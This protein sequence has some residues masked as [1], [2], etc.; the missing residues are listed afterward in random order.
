MPRLEHWYY[1]NSFLGTLPPRYK[2]LSLVEVYQ[3]LDAC[4]RLYMG[5]YTE[6]AVKVTY[7]GDVKIRGHVGVT[8]G[9]PTSRVGK[10]VI[11]FIETP[12]GS[13]RQIEKW[14]EWGFSSRIVEYPIK[15]VE[16]FKIMSYV[17]ENMHVSFNYEIYEKLKSNLKA[18]GMIW[19][20]FP[21][22]PFQRLL[23]D[24]VG[25]ERTI[26]LLF[27]HTRETESF[28]EV[29]ERS[30][31]QFYEVLGESPIK[32]LNFGDNIDA[33]ITSPKLFKKYCLPYYQKRSD[34]LHKK[35][36]FVHCHVDGYAKPLLPFFKETGWDG[37]EALTPKPVGD[38]TLEEIKEALG[39]EMILLDG[40]PYI[41]FLANVSYEKFKEFVRKILSIFSENLILGISDELPPVGDIER[42]KAVSRMLKESN[43]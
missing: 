35:G 32:I 12:I 40:I 43:F 3:D 36:K 29:I 9:E 37:V 30:D 18:Q 2:G 17:L 42:V 19:Y 1:V 39:D 41:Y 24:Y 31:D 25:I 16:D 23:I 5:Y 14:G 26:K 34:Y 27:R 22:T 28:M 13:L 33:R 8:Y 20:F 21:R 11:T 38:I 6:N 10:T 4:W 15:N 7:K